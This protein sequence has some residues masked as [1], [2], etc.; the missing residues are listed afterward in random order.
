MA[1][2]TNS[3]CQNPPKIVSPLH[4]TEKCVLSRIVAARNKSWKICMI[5]LK[6][7][8]FRVLEFFYF[9]T[10]VLAFSR[11]RRIMFIKDIDSTYAHTAAAHF[12]QNLTF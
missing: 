1:I 12:N 9:S 2:L 8:K 4:R 11:E 7:S 5:E 3:L 10:Y 6:L